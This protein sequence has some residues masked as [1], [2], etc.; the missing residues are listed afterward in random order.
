[1]QLVGAHHAEF[2]KTAIVGN[3]IGLQRAAKIGKPFPATGAGAAGQIG[4]DDN[5]VA[6]LDARDICRHRRNFAGIF[7]AGNDGK[8]TVTVTRMQHVDIGMAQPR[9]LYPDKGMPRRQIGDGHVSKH[10]TSL[11]DELNRMHGHLRL[12]SSSSCRRRH[13]MSGREYSRCRKR[14]GKLQGP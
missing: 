13:Y 5:P 6:D 3:A 10:G 7:M 1:M 2:R 9:S 4:I 12:F 14:R 11:L 8:G